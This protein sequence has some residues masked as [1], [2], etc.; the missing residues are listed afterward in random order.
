MSAPKVVLKASNKR[1][2][3]S[4]DDHPP[5][6]GTG[7]STGDQ[8]LKSPPSPKH[9]AGKGLMTGKGPIINDPV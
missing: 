9:G 4:K 1:K 7:L 5:K 3:E 2:S 6:K 8:Q